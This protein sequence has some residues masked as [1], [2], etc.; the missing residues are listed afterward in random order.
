MRDVLLVLAVWLLAGLPVGLLCGRHLRRLSEWD[1]GGRV[2]EQLRGQ[3]TSQARSE[4]RSQAPS[5]TRSQ[6]RSSM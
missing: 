5:Q 3:M 1:D 2:H 4:T 6:T